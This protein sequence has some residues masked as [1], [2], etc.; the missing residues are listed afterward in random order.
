MK[1]YDSSGTQVQDVVLGEFLRCLDF[2]YRQVN[3]VFCHTTM[4]LNARCRIKQLLF[5]DNIVLLE[6]SE[7]GTLQ[8]ALDWFSAVCDQV[9]MKI[10]TEN[11]EVLCL[12][13][14]PRQCMLQAANTAAGGEVQVPWVVH[15]S[16][17]K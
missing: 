16:Y 1:V 6:S 12:T 9:R 14:N 8:S 17:K 15:I 11:S 3:K 2:N 13:R 5:A 4:S 7:Q 10:A